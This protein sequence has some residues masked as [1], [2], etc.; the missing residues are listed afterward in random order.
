MTT[1]ATHS[2][3]DHTLMALADPTRRAILQRLFHGEARVTELAQPFDMSLNAVSKH[4]RM[5]ERAHLV[6]R[7]R[8][9]REHFLS[10]N[11]RPFDEAASWLETQRAFWASRL[12]DLDALLRAEDGAAPKPPVGKRKGRA[13]A[14]R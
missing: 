12:D 5:L 6:R 11:P 4:I 13:R 9:G 7:R 8:S 14:S 10:F 2:N 1:K 3:L